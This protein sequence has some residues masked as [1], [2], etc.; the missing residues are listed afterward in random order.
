MT[1]RAISIIQ[2]TVEIAVLGTA[3]AVALARA[4][5]LISLALSLVGIQPLIVMITSLVA[6]N[7]QLSSPALP[8]VFHLA[9]LVRI[10]GFVIILIAVARFPKKESQNM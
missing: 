4:R 2:L 5:H 9:Y 6:W 3:A 7:I 10:A 8:Y 1:A